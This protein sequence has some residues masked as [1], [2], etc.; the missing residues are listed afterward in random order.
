MERSKSL[1]FNYFMN[2]FLTASNIIFPFISFPYVSRI[3]APEG[4]GKI[5]FAQACV[6]YF[7]MF[8][9]L[10]IPTYGI[11]I[12]AK[13]RDDKKELSKTVQELFILNTISGILAYLLLVVCI[14]QIDE[15]RMEQKLFWI[16]SLT[17]IF[18]VVGVEWLYKAMEEYKYITIRSLVFK[19]ISI[20]LMFAMVHKKEDYLIYGGIAIFANVCS[21][22]FNFIHLRKVIPL[23]KPQ[24]YEFKKHI[25]PIF[26]FF[27]V[28]CATTVY[29]S[30][31]SVMLGFMSS[32]ATVG[33][34]NAAVKIK[35]VL[36]TM[37]TALG[38]VMLPRVSYYYQNKLYEQFRNVTRKAF[39]YIFVIAFPVSIYFV[40]MAKESI[41]FLSGSEYVPAVVP[42]MLIMPTVL[43]IGLS[44]LTGMQILVPQGRENVVLISVIVGAI[45]DAV[46]NYIY[47]PQY[48]A[49]GA[50]LGTTLAE[51]LVLLVQIFALRLE[52]K[53]YLAGIQYRKIVGAN[54]CAVISVLI[55][56]QIFTNVFVNNFVMLVVT[57]IAF[58]IIYFGVLFLT[59][60]TFTIEYLWKYIKRLIKKQDKL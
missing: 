2:M 24:K 13:V 31:D 6:S 56:K 38:A 44:N 5:S 32:D 60:E 33:Y 11:R 46:I 36:V 51:L 17:V 34:Y 45:L 57:A 22:A 23:I 42:M 47:I 8:A 41:L 15:F 28:T 29:T 19:V 52:I 16:N 26:T 58:A 20:I 10:G 53:K 40:L 35:K 12:C 50:A 4:L 48:G 54:V 55:I 59:E 43:L 9:M 30:L 3:L 14:F 25:I 49:T 37:V 39:N 27:M 18:N 1:K 7:S 21:Y